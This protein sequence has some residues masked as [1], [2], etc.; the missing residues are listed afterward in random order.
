MEL[1]N[2]CG[3]VEAL[4]EAAKA[5]RHGHPDDTIDRIPAR[6]RRI[7]NRLRWRAASR[8]EG[9]ER[10]AQHPLRED[11]RRRCADRSVRASRRPLASA[12]SAG[13]PV[14]TAARMIERGAE[15]PCSKAAHRESCVR[16][17]VRPGP[18]EKER[19]TLGTN[20]TPPPGFTP[21]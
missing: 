21:T 18:R 15:G 19:S 17:E 16:E 20:P 1:R 13:L 5:N 11:E 6:L 14:T 2:T 9:Q 4:I 10:D 8:P 12:V 7:T 3:E